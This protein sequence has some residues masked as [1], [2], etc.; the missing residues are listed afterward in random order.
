[1]TTSQQQTGKDSVIYARIA[2]L[3]GFTWV[4]GFVAPFTSHNLMY[5]FVILNTLQGLY[6]A[7]A[8]CFTKRVWLLYKK[9][10][11]KSQSKK[12]KEKADERESDKELRK[13]KD[14][15]KMRDIEDEESEKT[16]SSRFE[17]SKGMSTDESG[18]RGGTNYE[19]K[20]STK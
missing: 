17:H 9:S 14:G 16:Q 19:V 11:E 18:A 4:F 13:H 3:M 7:V 8:F 5:P 2:A 1:M 15:E 10:G 6:I 12:Q 20:P